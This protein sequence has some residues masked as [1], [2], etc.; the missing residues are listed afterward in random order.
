VPQ[1][2]VATTIPLA[3][4][5]AR[6]RLRLPQESDAMPLHAYFGDEASVRHTT[7]FAFTEAQTWRAVAGVVGH[8]FWRGYGPYALQ[9]KSDGAVVGLCG[10]WYPNDWPEPEIKW[11]LVPAA[12][13][14][15]LAA[16]AALAVRA[17]V[18]EHL[19]AWRPIS[20]I[21][22]DNF[23]SRALAE[24]VGAQF[25]SSVEFR[26]ATFHIYRHVA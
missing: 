17:M 22:A 26:G 3:I 5:S 6:L 4:E 13:G 9:R 2:G 16:E 11:S 19:P 24:R 8:W 23:A 12:R 18:R 10:L 1:L 21:H 7:G 15:G 25:E 14:A 20:Q